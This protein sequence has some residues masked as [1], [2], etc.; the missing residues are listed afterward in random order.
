MPGMPVSLSGD[1]S[2]GHGFSPSPIT[3]S[4]GSAAKLLIMG[5]VPHVQ[6]DVITPHVLGQAV[7]AGSVLNV[8]K[9]VFAG[10]M[11]IARVMDTG[12]CGAV[13]MG[14]GGTVLVGG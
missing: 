11:G 7:H 3:P 8:S 14:T 6:N 1:Q 9:T 4:G 12:D 13:I 2:M 5:K 10:G